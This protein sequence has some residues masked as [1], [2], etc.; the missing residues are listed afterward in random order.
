MAAGDS[1]I[2]G[3]YTYHLATGFRVVDFSN[4]TVKFSL[5]TDS[6]VPDIDNDEYWDDV[7][8]NE[9]T[10][11]DG[12]SGGYVLTINVAYNTATHRAEIDTTN[13]TWS[14][15]AEKTFRW[16]VLWEDTG[17]PSESPIVGWIDLGN[18]ARVNGFTV[19]IDRLLNF[20]PLAVTT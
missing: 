10:S 14:F 11:S 18:S 20:L 6:W 5:L 16:G 19:G 13:P 12:Y 15:T 3:R 4:A 1:Q 7:Y 17:T 8:L 9:L 2:A